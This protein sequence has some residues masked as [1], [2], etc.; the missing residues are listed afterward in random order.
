MKGKPET[1]AGAEYS[2]KI[3]FRSVREYRRESLLAPLFVSLESLME[4]LIPFVT[5]QLVNQVSHGAPLLSIARDGAWTVFMA[6]LSLA[7]GIL[8]GNSCATASCGLAKNLRSDLFRTLQGFSFENIDRFSPASL[9]TRLTTDVINVQNAYMM[10]I[11][12]AV[13]APL[14]LL[15]SLIMAAVMGGSMALIFLFAAPVMGFGLWTIARFAMPVF[16]SLFHRYD[17]LNASVRE[18][19]AGIKVVKA[20]AREDYEK[21]KFRAAA[22]GLA[23]DFTRAERILSLNAPL[24]QFCMYV[25]MLAMLSIGPYVIA[26]SHGR[27]LDVGQLTSLLSYGMMILFSLMM[28]SRVFVMIAMARE[29]AARIAEVLTEKSSIPSPKDGVHKV[30]DGSIDFDGVSFRYNNRGGGLMA[31]RGVALHINSGETIGIVGA[32]GSGKSTLVQLIPRLYDASKGV[33]R[34]GGL[35][36]RDYDLTALRHSVGMVLQKNLLFSGTVRE[37]LLWGDMEADDDE[38]MAACRASCADEFIERLP[39]GLDS[40]VEQG[41]ANFSGGQRQRL[42]IAR[43]LLARPAIL[44]LDDSTSAV[45][46][47]TDA[48]IRAAMQSYMPG[49]TKIIIAQRIAQVQDADRIAVISDGTLA[50]VGGHEELMRS[51]GI[52]RE[53]CALQRTGAA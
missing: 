41:G 3:L 38:I 42:C 18:N 11:R 5:A 26:A 50:A 36:V 39:N 19:I 30:P 31:L 10:L 46:T 34:V 44:I 7:F 12:A 33:V 28:L 48:A 22:Q 25:V 53:T 29:S 14:M 52:Y 49:T 51:C 40:R 37:N 4:C 35:D 27:A 13:R 23:S 15:F 1:G 32:S 45:D 24:M 43:A 6:L 47:G 8:A 9:V 20:F 17:A 16:R 2:L 21:A